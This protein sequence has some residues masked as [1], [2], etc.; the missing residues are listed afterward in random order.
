MDM[1]KT[2]P[3]D[4]RTRGKGGD[5]TRKGLSP[6]LSS[7]EDEGERRGRGKCWLAGW[8]GENPSHCQSNWLL[9]GP[10]PPAAECPVLPLC[11]A[12]CGPLIDGSAG[13]LA[14]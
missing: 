8:L 11:Q 1:E 4:P 7:P 5:V 10:D 14:W 13:Q 6:S 12:R 3:G 9:P 2:K